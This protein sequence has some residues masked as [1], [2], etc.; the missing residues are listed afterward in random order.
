MSKLDAPTSE[1]NHKRQDTLAKIVAHSKSYGFIYPSSE[2]YGHLQA[3]YDYG[4]YGALLKRNVSAYWWLSMTRMH[5]NIVGLDAAILMHAKTWDASGHTAH[6]SDFFVDNKDSKRRY[7]IDTLI[8]AH[9]QSLEDASKP[10]EAR[11]VQDAL[12]RAL[13][14]EDVRALGD[15]LVSLPIVCPTSGTSHWTPV[16]RLNLMFETQAG[17]SQTDAQPLFCARKPPK[18]SMLI[19]LIFKKA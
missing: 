5:A 10:Q 14:A 11:K 8:E 9:I 16:R 7:R 3:V 15:L 6:F 19:F 17:A 12:A 2:I 18:V 13:A 4:P 1:S